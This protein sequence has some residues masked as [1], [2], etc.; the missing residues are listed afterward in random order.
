[1]EDNP[2][3]CE[4]CEFLSACTFQGIGMIRKTYSDYEFR[5]GHCY[6]PIHLNYASN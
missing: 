5:A 3:E 2:F 4:K 6:G 1:M